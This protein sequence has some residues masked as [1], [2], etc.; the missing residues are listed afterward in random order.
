M[1]YADAVI[2]KQ[3]DT[4]VT[5]EFTYGKGQDRHWVS[6]IELPIS[7]AL[8]LESSLIA[9]CKAQEAHRARKRSEDNRVH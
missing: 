3:H 8:D 1:H 2:V 9:N 5:V 7:T 6:S 4:I